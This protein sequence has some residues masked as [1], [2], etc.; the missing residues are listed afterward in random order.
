MTRRL[1]GVCLVLA[2]LSGL[3]ARGVGKP[4][5]LPDDQ[6]ITVTPLRV[7]TFESVLPVSDT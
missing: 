7:Q 6:K 1:L 3:A 5:D 4:P 2:A